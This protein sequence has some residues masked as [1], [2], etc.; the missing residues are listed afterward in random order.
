MS[1]FKSQPSNKTID[2]NLLLLML[3]ATGIFIVAN[4]Y[5]AFVVSEAKQSSNPYVCEVYLHTNPN[6]T[7]VYQ[8]AKK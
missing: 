7:H 5:V 4:A 6:Q 1:E 3:F 2:T 8:G